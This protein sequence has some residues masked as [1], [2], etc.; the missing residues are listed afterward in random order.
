MNNTKM[1]LRN[2]WDLAT[3]TLQIGTAIPSLPVTHTQIYN[4]SRIF[5]S[6]VST[7]SP[8][9]KIVF[10]FDSVEYIDSFA[11]WRHNLTVDSRV[12]LQLFEGI[13][14]TG[15]LV[16]DS[17]F[18]EGDIPKTLGDLSWGR[19]EL[20]ASSN[21]DWKLKSR[22][23]W[24]DQPVAARSGILT[25]IDK[26]NP[27]GYIEIGR[28][29]CGDAFSPTINVDLGHSF[30]WDSDSEVLPTAGGTVHSIYSEVYRTL[31]FNMSHLT[32]ADRAVFAEALRTVSKT[33]DIFVSLRPGVGGATERDYTFAGKF[34]EVPRLTAQ[35]SRYETTCTIREV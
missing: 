7:D 14:R 26:E 21:T 32:S 3:V 16:F 10:D 8:D 15:A 19:D 6:P 33:N 27:D 22:S 2:A 35:P 25:I 20:G 29:Y 4:N 5:R 24:L 18:F 28:I 30:S 17:G 23:K 1:I 11:M 9:T 13:N 12:R 34:V 31:T